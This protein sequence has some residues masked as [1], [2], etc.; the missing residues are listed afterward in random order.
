MSTTD[1]RIERAKQGAAAEA[2]RA[3]K[4]EAEVRAAV[5]RAEEFHSDSRLQAHYDL[6]DREEAAREEAERRTAVQRENRREREFEEKLQTHYQ[7]SLEWHKLTRPDVPASIFDREV[8][9]EM[10]RKFIAGKED[11]A[12]Q[13]RRER[14]AK[15]F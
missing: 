8:W 7:K 9:P 11:S 4:S 5:E 2:R 1:E 6:M 15:V 13:E 14:S 3:G 12:D 10:K